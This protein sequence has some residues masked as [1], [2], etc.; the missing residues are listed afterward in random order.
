[1]RSMR[2]LHTKLFQDDIGLNTC[3]P[4]ITDKQYNV[5]PIDMDLSHQPPTYTYP[6]NSFNYEM[7]PNVCFDNNQTYT[8]SK[9]YFPGKTQ[10][11]NEV[12]D[13]EL[14][15]KPC[16]V[17]YCPKEFYSGVE[18]SQN[19]VPLGGEWLTQKN[20]T[21]VTENRNFVTNSNLQNP[22]VQ[23]SNPLGNNVVRKGTPVIP[24]KSN[25]IGHQISNG[26]LAL[27]SLLPG[28][29]ENR[30]RVWVR[31]NRYPAQ[32]PVSNIYIQPDYHGEPYVNSLYE[33]PYDQAKNV[34]STGFLMNPY[35][36]VV[37]ETFENQLPPPNTTKGS[38]PNYQ[39]DQVN[40]KLV[41]LKGGY[42]HHRPPHRKREQPGWVFNP[43]SARGGSLPFGEQVY[44]PY[45]R[46][47]LTKLV[48]RDIYNNQNGNYPVE[49]SMNGERPSGMFG[50]VPRTRAVPYLP[51]THSANQSSNRFNTAD[52]M[53]ADLTKR[54]EYTGQWFSRKAHLL[55]TD[56]AQ[57]PTTLL[58]GVDAVA[59][60]PINTDREGKVND[61]SQCYTIAPH[62][63]NVD[64]TL[65]LDRQ[66]REVDPLVTQTFP[67]G[68]L[69][70]PVQDQTLI[71]D[72]NLRE[73][74]ELM[75]ET[76]PLGGLNGPNADRTV[77]V[78]R[79][80]K[81]VDQLV[82]EAFP[83]LG[84][85]GQDTGTIV[86]DRELRET[87][88]ATMEN[89]YRTAPAGMDHTGTLM[90]TNIQLHKPTQ[91]GG[92]PFL[93]WLPPATLPNSGNNQL[94]AQKMTSLQTRGKCEQNYI[95]SQSLIN[96]YGGSDTNT[97][98]LQPLL[99]QKRG[100]SGAANWNPHAIPELFGTAG[101][102]NL[103]F[104]SIRPTIRGRQESCDDREDT[105]D[106]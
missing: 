40:P 38:I 65:I 37:T 24:V 88:K 15:H 11:P 71:V 100:A 89:P 36:G 74:D 18:L 92:Q 16:N 90:E 70:G 94:T 62:L 101:T 91:I 32:K 59:S 69:Q 49:W 83:A 68:S 53:S 39:L 6:T 9:Y 20:D 23:L 46:E 52:V 34:I 12:V 42:N 104:H 98:V 8:N 72:R 45:I 22:N 1:M 57:Y 2:H 56:R 43:V 93:N 86:T 10:Y 13:G 63:D 103:M 54:E 73:V 31:E 5:Q 77:I 17:S 66:L 55:V 35:T 19:K 21:N 76:L 50:Y 61:L 4:H 64:N 85:D 58:N 48:S 105:Q 51:A 97:R 44:T 106:F 28:Q 102:K 27:D 41:H 47:N 82:Q 95:P 25:E 78:D 99:R 7:Y 3:I 60:I 14:R 79:T 96:T 26:G 81:E 33:T 29:Q 84:L 67:E 30:E 87:L 80:L 75:Q